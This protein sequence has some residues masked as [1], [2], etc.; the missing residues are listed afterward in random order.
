MIEVTGLLTI[1][2]TGVGAWIA[3]NQFRIAQANLRLALFDRRFAVFESAR[4]FL[5]RVGRDNAVKLSDVSTFS[6]GTLDA[7]FLFDV[8]IVAYFQE[9]RDRALKWRSDDVMYERGPRAGEQSLLD[10]REDGMRWLMAQLDELPKRLQPYM[11]FDEWRL[12]SPFYVKW[13]DK[14]RSGLQ[15]RKPP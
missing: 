14:A 9:I 12:E 4:E 5:V 15:N 11:A 13:I 7:G 3:Y 8:G 10:S 1:L 2:L 6:R